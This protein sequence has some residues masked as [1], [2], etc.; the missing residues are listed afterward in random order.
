MKCNIS[1]EAQHHPEWSACSILSLHQATVAALY[2]YLHEMSPRLFW[3]WLWPPPPRSWEWWAHVSTAVCRFLPKLHHPA[4]EMYCRPFIVRTLKV[5]V[6]WEYF[7]VK[8]PRP[9]WWPIGGFSFAGPPY[10]LQ[11]LTA[12]YVKRAHLHFYRDFHNLCSSKM[13]FTIKQTFFGTW[14]L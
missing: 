9:D 12:W 5:R 10:E 7:S 3:Q 8:H 13:H 1:Q 6:C 14:A 11:I 4:L 2:H